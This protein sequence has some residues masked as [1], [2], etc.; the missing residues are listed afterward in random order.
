MKDCGQSDVSLSQTSCCSGTVQPCK[1]RY[2]CMATTKFFPMS[3]N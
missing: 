2:S 3:V 1:W